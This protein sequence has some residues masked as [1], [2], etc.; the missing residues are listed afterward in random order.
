[1][2]EP[3][4]KQKLRVLVAEDEYWARI[5]IC[6]LI[7]SFGDK[8]AVL[9][10]AV[11]GKDALEKLA[12][13]QA[14]ILITDI[15]MPVMDG[16]QLTA[17]VSRL[18]PELA[19]IVVSGYNDF[20]YVRSTLLNGAIDYLLKPVSPEELQAVLEKAAGKRAD[21][22]TTR[23][24]LNAAASA[25]YDMRMS[26]LLSPA[27]GGQPMLTEKEIEYEL[28]YP[29]FTPVLIY[30][31][32]RVAPSAVLPLKETIH[33]ACNDGTMLVFHH[34]YHPSEF[35]LLTQLTAGELDGACRTLLSV[36][37]AK[38]DLCLTIVIGAYCYSFSKLKLAYDGM[39]E[40]RMYRPYNMRS[41]VLHVGAEARRPAIVQRI[42][43][44]QR[45][46]LLFAC[47]TGNRELFFHV[48]YGDC[49]LKD[50]QKSGWL[51]IEVRRTVDEAVSCMR[52]YADERNA[53]QAQ[54][55]FDNLYELLLLAIEGERL[56]DLCS[57]LEQLADETFGSSS[58]LKQSQ[59][60]QHI[61]VQVQQFIAKEYA[62][63]ISLSAFASR[64]AVDGS[65][66]SRAFKEAVGQNLMYYIA[67]VR[68][69]HAV[70]LMRRR[71]LTIVEV[72]QL[73]GYDDYAYFNRVFKK[74][75]GQSPRAYRQS[76]LADREHA[77]N[78]GV[79]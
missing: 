15:T 17:E 79:P 38:T 36:L 13:S 78:G 50:C 39:Q 48:L 62:E 42:S 35:I 33:A 63:D 45:K 52:T 68:I 75:T 73:V 8:Y 31:R 14:D 41:L 6:S 54:Q 61:I 69:Q 60:M 51:L 29:G 21:L 71:D 47:S 70:E 24:K 5:N 3:E 19:I 25:E 16:T 4:T 9:E 74:I 55:D 1:M 22:H 77:E 67:H 56:P 59:S 27:E 40:E 64:Y 37:H 46:Q 34:V 58:L 65:Y 76:L 10:A 2:S 44:D 26:A 66:L 20:S 43:L 49:K 23:Q 72:S 7:T 32:G 28:S 53:A 30:L 12:A 57:L 11:D 18:Y